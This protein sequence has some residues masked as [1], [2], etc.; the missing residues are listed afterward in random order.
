[1][2]NGKK[3]NIT[4]EGVSRVEIGGYTHQYPGKV[5]TKMYVS[6]VNKPLVVDDADVTK[7][8]KRFAVEMRVVED[9]TPSQNVV[10]TKVAEMEQ[11][12]D[13]D[14]P[15]ARGTTSTTRT[16]EAPEAE[17]PVGTDPL[18][19]GERFLKNMIKTNTAWL[20]LIA[21]VAILALVVGA[22]ALALV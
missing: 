10:Y 3:T 20:L 18:S 21:G 11:I 16:T 17:A 1:M 15:T 7:K 22:V 8:L 19:K 12:M 6:D 2:S 9:K 4:D 14:S 13:G 5:V